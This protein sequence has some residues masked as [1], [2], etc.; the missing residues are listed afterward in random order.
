MKVVCH[1][2]DA[3]NNTDPERAEA[4]KCGKCGTELLPAAP[5]YPLSATEANFEQLVLKSQ[6]P[7]LVDFYT[8]WCGPCR[9]LAPLVKQFA[10]EAAGKVKVVKVDAEACANISRTHRI[11]GYPTLVLFDQGKEVNR[12]MGFT[13]VPGLHRLAQL[14]KG[15]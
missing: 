9:H 13:N 10:R 2:C 15:E 7:V 14:S 3:V 11:S 5:G 1:E 4:P 12:H 6:V 8:T